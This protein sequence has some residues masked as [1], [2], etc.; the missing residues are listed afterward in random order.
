MNL[1]S[2]ISN[3]LIPAK[4]EAMY[5]TYRCNR[6]NYFGH[7]STRKFSG[8]R[9]ARRFERDILRKKQRQIDGSQTQTCYNYMPCDSCRFC[10]R[11]L[12]CADRR[13]LGITK[14]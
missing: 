8:D 2:L 14:R 7:A 11:I 10:N 13:N 1:S 6:G 4:N 9:R 12:H 3:L 5:T